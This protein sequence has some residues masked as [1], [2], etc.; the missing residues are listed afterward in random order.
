MDISIAEA[1]TDDFE[2]YPTFAIDNIGQWLMYDG[3]KKTT[4]GISGVDYDHK[5]DP[6]AFQVINFDDLCM[7]MKM[8][9][10]HGHLIAEYN[11]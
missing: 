1:I 3:D 6:K 11:T 7:K 9:K 2:S 5:N 4:Y 10:K 8:L